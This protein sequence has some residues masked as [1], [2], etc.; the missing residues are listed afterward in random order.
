MARSYWVMNTTRF[1]QDEIWKKLPKAYIS[2]TE[3]HVG[4]NFLLDSPGTEVGTP[5]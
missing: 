1:D 5:P 2:I 3:F 4:A